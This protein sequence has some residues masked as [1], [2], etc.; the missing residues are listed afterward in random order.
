MCLVLGVCPSRIIPC[1]L[2]FCSRQKKKLPYLHLGYCSQLLRLCVVTCHLSVR[3]CPTEVGEPS[4]AVLH[5][6]ISSLATCFLTAALTFDCCFMLRHEE[7]ADYFCLYY[8]VCARV[9]CDDR[10]VLPYP[11]FFCPQPCSLNFTQFTVQRLRHSCNIPTCVRVLL[12]FSRPF[13]P[14]LYPFLLCF[15][16]SRCPLFCARG[17]VVGGDWTQVCL[18]FR[19]CFI[20]G[21]FGVL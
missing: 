20:Y 6:C 11:S 3:N 12:V 10:Q 17:S 8:G 18:G 16:C 21:G 14:F 19:H 9:A 13:I 4:G 1:R 5:T 2:G 15:T 7:H